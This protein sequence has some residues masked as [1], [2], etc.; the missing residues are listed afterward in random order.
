[1]LVFAEL[2]EI[3]S[4][5]EYQDMGEKKFAIASLCAGIFLFV[6]LMIASFFPIQKCSV[7]GNRF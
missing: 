1:M 2:P 4:A 7:I 5:K 6:S 3:L